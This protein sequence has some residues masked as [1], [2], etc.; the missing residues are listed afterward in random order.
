MSERRQRIEL[1]FPNALDLLQVSI[2]TGLGFD[3]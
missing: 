3:A 2:E 1:A